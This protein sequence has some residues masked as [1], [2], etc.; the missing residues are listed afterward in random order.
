M[1]PIGDNVPRSRVPLI[2]WTLIL[3]NVLIYFWQSQLSEMEMVEFFYSFGVVPRILL[4]ADSGRIWTL[5]TSM[6]LHGNIGHLIGNMWI[7]GLFGDNV[8]DRMGRFSLLVFYIL[9]GIF[10][11]IV[12][13]LV[14]PASMV[15]TI[16]A[17]GA[18]AGVM[19]GYFFLFPLARV[20]A[21]IPIFIFPYFIRVPSFIF[22]G[23]WFVTQLYYGALALEVTS[24][25]GIAWWAHIGGFLFGSLTYRFFRKRI[26]RI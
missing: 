23:I 4:T 10:A 19:A 7:L 8:E 12:H 3:L 24:F 20:T 16:G 21:I 15:P 5:F 9:T 22:I 18:I 25:G 13:I 1:I 6:F 2:T 11:G 26:N 17:S 14:N